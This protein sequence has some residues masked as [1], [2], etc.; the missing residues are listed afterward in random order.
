MD[1][2]AACRF[3]VESMRGVRDSGFRKLFDHFLSHTNCGF[4]SAFSYH[5]R[6]IVCR[7]FLLSV[8]VPFGSAVCCCFQKEIL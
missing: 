6:F 3:F 7:A 8:P 1:T 2:G 5:G 4:C